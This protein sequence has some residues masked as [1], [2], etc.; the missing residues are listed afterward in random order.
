MASSRKRKRVTL[1]IDTKLEILK[2]LDNGVR[3]SNIAIEYGIG[4]STVTD[5]RKSQEKI[6][7]FA[8]EAEDSGAVKSR[9]I[10]RKAAADDFDKAMHL[11]FAQE[12]S[13]G[14]PISGVMVTEK[15][16]LLY[17]EMYPDEGDDHFKASTGWLCRFKNRHGI[18][19]L[20]MQ[21]EFLTA[22]WNAAGEFKYA[23][24]SFIEQHKLIRDQVFSCNKTGLYWRLLPNKFLAESSEKQVNNFKVSKDRV[25]LMATANANGDFRLPLVFVHKSVK[26]RCFAN[27]TMSA[28]PVHYYSQRSTWIDKGIFSDWFFKHFVPLVKDYLTSKS[29]PVRAVLLMDNAPSHPAIENLFTEDG[30]IRCLFLPPSIKSLIQPMDQGVL[31]NMKHR[32]KRNLLRRLLLGSM[33]FESCTDFCKQL[34]IKDAVYMCAKSW[35]EISSESLRRSWN[36]LWPCIDNTESDNLRNDEETEIKQLNF[37]EEQQLLDLTTEEQEEWL[38]ADKHEN[39]HP[40]LSD[41]EIIELVRETA[42][43]DSDKKGESAKKI[44]HMQAEQC[45]ATC[46]QWLEQQPEATPV[47]LMMLQELHTLAAKKL[48]SKLK[49]NT[50]KDFLK[51]T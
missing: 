11:W 17:R 25:T 10:V 33:Q 29:L 15:A 21:G 23:F 9:C 43:P 42:Q 44:P 8:K 40:I 46:L 26:P 4:K 27:I 3:L 45:F 19:Q 30:S 41:H 34:T 7:Q 13:K 1:S 49:Q 35:S 12:R 24:K 22:D 5:I 38:N 6:K 28:L 37:S 47:N 50:I 2:K 16:K 32:Y 18:R 39:G 31:E 14:T 48:V 36:T 20:R 51:S